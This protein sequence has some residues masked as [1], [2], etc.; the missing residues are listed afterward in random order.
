MVW[1][2]EYTQKRMTPAAVVALIP[3]DAKMVMPIATG[4]P[5]VLLDALAARGCRAITTCG[6]K[7]YYCH[8]PFGLFG[9]T[10]CWQN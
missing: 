3:E 4:E 10:F 1:T 6:V 5:Q 2:K 8:E 7:R 9:A